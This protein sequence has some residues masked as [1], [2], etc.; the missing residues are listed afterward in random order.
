MKPLITFSV[1]LFAATVSLTTQARG[2]HKSKPL[3]FEEL[4]S[5][6]Q[7]YFKRAEACYAKV[8]EQ[9]SLFHKGNTEFLRQVLPAALP[10]Q[11]VRMCE[12]AD[13]DFAAKA[14]Q[15]KCE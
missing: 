11:R 2:M 14:A 6:C 5:V 8:D 13:R 12:I 10:E 15:L 1:L 4:P 9:T 7:A 3:S